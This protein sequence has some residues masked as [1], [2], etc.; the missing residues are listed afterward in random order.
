[1][2]IYAV[3]GGRREKPDSVQRTAGL[4]NLICYATLNSLVNF[5]RS[6]LGRRESCGE[7]H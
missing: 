3:C 5:M 2:E 6:Y 4:A 1:M 7:L